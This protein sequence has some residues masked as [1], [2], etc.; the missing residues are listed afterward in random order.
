MSGLKELDFR[1]AVS[2]SLSSETLLDD[3][4]SIDSNVGGLTYSESNG[5]KGTLFVMHHL[6]SFNGVGRQ[7]AAFKHTRSHLEYLFITK[8]KLEKT[9][10]FRAET[11]LK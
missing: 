11:G 10:F 2:K 8:K 9:L 1:D 6:L 7:V 3:K 5:C 4:K